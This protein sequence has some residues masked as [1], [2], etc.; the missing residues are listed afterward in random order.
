MSSQVETS[1]A[2]IAVKLSDDLVQDPT[3][4]RLK[5]L[6]SFTI[7]KHKKVELDCFAKKPL[8]PK[9]VTI[10]RFPFKPDSSNTTNNYARHKFPDQFLGKM[11]ISFFD[12]LL[13]NKAS[14]RSEA[15]V[16][17]MFENGLVPG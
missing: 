16:G 6:S 7:K 10:S 14:K 9:K 2:E 8:S 1:Q 15:I 4:S 3:L 13:E 12:S 17:W 11:L 5:L